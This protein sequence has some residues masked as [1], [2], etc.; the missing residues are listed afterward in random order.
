VFLDI[1][2]IEIDTPKGSRYDLT[3]SVA[4]GQAAKPQIAA[5]FRSRAS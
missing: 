1:N 4:T 3:I 2:N 5:F